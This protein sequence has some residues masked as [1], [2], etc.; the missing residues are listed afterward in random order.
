MSKDDIALE[1]QNFCKIPTHGSHSPCVDWGTHWQESDEVRDLVSH[2]LVSVNSVRLCKTIRGVP[3]LS[4]AESPVSFES[5]LPVRIFVQELSAG[6]PCPEECP[7]IAQVTLSG[8]E[9]V[10]WEFA[11]R[12]TSSTVLECHLPWFSGNRSLAHLPASMLLDSRKEDGN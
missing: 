3:S 10:A 5:S 4:D 12:P 2:G 1:A 7:F 8:R 11:T 9:S 6:N